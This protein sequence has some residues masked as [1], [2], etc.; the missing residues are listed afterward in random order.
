MGM[1]KNNNGLNYKLHEFLG[2][3]QQIEEL[4]TLFQ[5]FLQRSKPIDFKC[6]TLSELNAKHEEYFKFLIEKT[7]IFY[8]SQ[9]N[10]LIFFIAFDFFLQTLEIPKEFN[11]DEKICEFVFAASRNFNKNLFQNA[12]YDIYQLLKQK[13]GVKYI[14]GNICRKHKKQ[15]FVA[16][17]QKVFNFQFIRDFA[18]HEI[19]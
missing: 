4:K 12:S 7:K 13:Y 19:P 9:N 6:R 16:L 17:A 2:D 8:A 5:D 18:Y 11:K 3:A 10:S 15:P 1:V 14:A